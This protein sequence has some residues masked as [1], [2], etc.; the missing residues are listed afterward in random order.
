MSHTGFNN[1]TEREYYSLC[2]KLDACPSCR[3][4]NFQHWS[5]EFTELG[6]KRLVFTCYACDRIHFFH[7]RFLDLRYVE[8][9]DGSDL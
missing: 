5:L 7:G 4:S 8:D 6:D 3:T 1:L 9:E 2:A